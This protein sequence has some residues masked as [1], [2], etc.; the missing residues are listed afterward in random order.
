MIILANI[1]QIKGADNGNPPDKLSEAYPKINRSL[2][3]VNNQVINHENRLGTAEAAVSDH[4]SRIIEAEAG[5]V[6]QQAQI[7]TLVLNGDSSPAAAQAAVDAEGHDYGNLKVRL[8]TEHTVL[9]EQ[10]A[11]ITS[12]AA[13]KSLTIPTGNAVNV[14]ID[15]YTKGRYVIR[16]TGVNNGYSCIVLNDGR[17][18]VRTYDFNNAWLNDLKAGSYVYHKGFGGQQ[19]DTQT[20]GVYPENSLRAFE[21]AGELGFRCIELDTQV[22]GDGTWV[23]EHETNTGNLTGSAANLDTITLADYKSR[24]TYRQ[25]TSGGNYWNYTGDQADYTPLTLEEALLIAKKQGYYVVAEI[26]YAATYTYTDADFQ[27]FADIVKRCGME[28]RVIVYSSGPLVIGV[29]KYL[30]NAIAGFKVGTTE[31]DVNRMKSY[32]NYVTVLS[33][34][35]FTESYAT[36]C[37]SYDIPS[38][39]WTVDNLETAETMFARG[40][41]L[42]TTNLL[43]S[44]I[45]LSDYFPL[46]KYNTPDIIGKF[47]ETKSSGDTG[48][49]TLDAN[50]IIQ[51]SSS[52]YLGRVKTIPS[53]SLKRGDIIRIRA[54]GKTL[55]QTGNNFARMSVSNRKSGLL[56]RQVFARFRTTEYETKEVYYVVPDEAENI[57]IG[58]GL[59]SQGYQG[60]SVASFKNVEVTIFTKKDSIALSDERY[61]ILTAFD[62]LLAVRGT[63]VNH[64]IVRTFVESD[65]SVLCVEYVPFSFRNGNPI[66]IAQQVDYSTAWTNKVVP[67]AENA[68]DNVVRFKIYDSAGAQIPNIT[69]LRMG[70]HLLIKN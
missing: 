50:G 40:A 12:L 43:I 26:K 7:D 66:V 25:Y 53:T 33:Y 63:G 55:S 45:N 14:N 67:V 42:V 30:P 64:G 19:A 34:T 49:S 56:L 59:E 38:I 16:A 70:F 21:A 8:D 23:V 65:P 22:L 28:E 61:C 27:A 20:K 69:S 47:A 44:E 68:S 9:S 15:A 13:L 62:S 51:M 52:A 1:E 6:E 32:R 37:K 17:F 4:G 18:A 31:A 46:L 39:V 11:E 29:M 58:I 35:E 3:N 48:S 57:T 36:F 10:L 41:T 54:T 5:L 2:V 60:S 24:T